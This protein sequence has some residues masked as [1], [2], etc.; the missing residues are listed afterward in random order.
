MKRDSLQF[1]AVL[2]CLL[3]V[4]AS[5]LPPGYFITDADLNS[6]YVT[7]MLDPVDPQDAATK[8][9]VDTL[10]GGVGGSSIQDTD[11][12]TMVQTE[13]AADEDII[14]F[15]TAGVERATIS[16]TGVIAITGNITIAAGKQIDGRDISSIPPFVNTSTGV[17]DAS[18]GVILGANGRMAT[19][20]L[21]SGTANATKYL[22]GDQTWATIA[23]GGD[24]TKAVYDTDNDSI[25]DKAENVDDGAGNASTAAQ[26]KT[27]VTNSHVNP[28]TAPTVY[29]NTSVGAAD[30]G[31]G[32]ASCAAARG[33]SQA[34]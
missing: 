17:A 28:P 9:Y 16:A 15:D 4:C 6:H 24:M 8:N 22:R 32:E 30:A 1:L 33:G 31:K 10:V 20:I 25:A 23:S 21:A 18:K 34:A 26:V 3:M 5:C 13:E 14:R 12:D 11:S 29:V 27:A 7:E 2:L 19:S